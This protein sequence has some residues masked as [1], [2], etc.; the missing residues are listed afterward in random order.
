[1]YVEEWNMLYGGRI[2][3]CVGTGVRTRLEICCVGAGSEDGL[4]I[5]YVGAG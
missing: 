4:E 1:M 2:R 5:C 3:C